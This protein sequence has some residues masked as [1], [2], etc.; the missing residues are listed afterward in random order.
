M[1][2]NSAFKGLNAFTIV[3]CTEV[4]SI[5]RIKDPYSAPRREFE[6]LKQNK[7]E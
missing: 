2:F 1:G 5:S 6:R 7:L 4:R 3:H